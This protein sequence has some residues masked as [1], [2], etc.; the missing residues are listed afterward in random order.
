MLLLYAPWL[1]ILWRQATEPPVPPWREAWQSA[2]AVQGALQEAVAALLIG[3]TPVGPLWLWA[4]AAVVVAALAVLLCR[5]RRG[6]I[7]L[8]ALVGLPVLALF[9]V[10]LVGPP[11][12]HVRYLFAFGAP[13]ALIIGAA[14]VGITDR[15][16]PLGYAAGALFLIA[17]ALGL[18]AFWNDP[19]YRADDHRAAVRTLAAEWRPGD[20]IF[21]NA[22][23]ITPLLEVYWPQ[24]GDG[25]DAVPP[26]LAT[27]VRLVDAKPTLALPMGEESVPLVRGGSVGGDA[28]LGW[29]NPASDFFAIS[30]QETA[31]GLADLQ[32]RYRRLWHYRL[33]DTVSDPEGVVRAW[34]DTETTLAQARPIPGR[35]FGLVEL[36]DFG[37]PVAPPGKGFA[38]VD[39]GGQVRLA[40]AAW[41]AAVDAGQMLYVALI[42][43][44]APD[45]LAALNMSLR[46]YDGDGKL[47]TQA[48]SPLEA[49]GALAAPP[50]LPDGPYALELVVYSAADG[51][52]LPVGDAR[53]GDGQRVRL[54][55]VEVKNRG[56]HE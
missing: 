35:D 43:A 38:P 10:S 4:L 34:L 55:E 2:G 14:L 36:R 50:W 33:Y 48:D 51:V 40:D 15:S 22:G 56:E 53:S 49:M 30:P 5:A 8:L 3:Q 11:L 24:A 31:A 52:A 41:S 17:Y 54:G 19:A 47:I 23:W 29:G 44:G 20:V 42:W 13:F 27:A 37:H 7:A 28:T 26:P 6:V 9:V 18:R 32:A 21:A 25:P 12:Y 45:R 16:R 46:L 39:F 1:P